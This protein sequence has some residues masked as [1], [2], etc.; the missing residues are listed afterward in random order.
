MLDIYK[1]ANG[2]LVNNKVLFIIETK[3]V[4]KPTDWL[5]KAAEKFG[6]NKQDCKIIE[7]NP[8]SDKHH[9]CHAYAAYS[10][11]GFKDASILIID[12]MNEP[13]GISI[14]IFK[15]ENDKIELIKSYP[16]AYSLGSF[17]ANGVVLCGFNDVDHAGK[18][19]GASSYSKNIRDC[20]PFFLVDKYTGEIIEENA[21]FITNNKYLKFIGDDFLEKMIGS[22][23]IS[24]K[25]QFDFTNILTASTVQHLFEQSVFSLLEYMHNTL[26][27]KN[28]VISGGCALNCVCNGKIIRSKKWNDLFIP[29]MC[30]DQGNIIGRMVMEYNQKISKPFI[31]NNIT[32]KIPKEYNKII[33]KS[34]LADKIR[35]GQ[36][37]AW[38]E[39]GSEYGPRA[40]CHRS[41]LANPEIPWMAYRVNEIKHREYWRPLAP[42][43]LDKYFKEIFDVDGRIWYPHKVML[44]TEYIR[45]QYQRKYQT[46]CA[47]DNS[48]RP[49]VLSDIKENHTLYSLMDN[50]DL[51]ILMNTSMNDAGKPIC[52]TPNDAINFCNKNTDIMLVF[53]K[54]DKIYIK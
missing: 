13:N 46:I 38:F 12:G 36:I 52:E 50:F 11:S 53:V 7:N 3:K 41:I 10:Q 17:Y 23:N 9:L 2:L 40:L 14:A 33:S 25:T 6:I 37:V 48:S 15:A 19:M 45:E 54:D 43:I 5:F 26:P 51:P 47:P 22:K 16:T 24:P 42:V 32:Y 29:N 27:S 4:D 49:Q 31:Y 30:E 18:L 34:E 35:K 44:A 28:L 39:G 21:K 8:T 1:G 20:P